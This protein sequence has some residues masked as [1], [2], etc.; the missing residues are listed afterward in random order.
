MGATGKT[1]TGFF[2]GGGGVVATSQPPQ[3]PNAPAPTVTIPPVN[4]NNPQVADQTPNDQNTPVT[5]NGLQRVSS[6]TDDELAALV[7]ASKKAIMPNFLADRADATQKFVF[8]AGLNDKPTVLDAND[9]NQYL[10]DNNINKNTIIARSV[11]GATYQNQQGYNV[12]YTAQQVQDMLM[13]SKLTYIGGKQGGQA[14]GA[15]AYF[16][17]VGD[18]GGTGYGSNTAVAVLN[19]KTAK[20]IDDYSLSRKAKSFA[21]SH[22]KFDKAVGGFNGRNQS[23][24]ALAMGY[25]VITDHSATNGKYIRTGSRGQ[26]TGDYYNI[27]DRSALVYR[28]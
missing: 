7:T 22:P 12:T 1:G 24:W 10:K 25:N 23:I 11:N 8:Q 20:I 3:T 9:F 5:P 19:P 2:G 18:N 21:Q 6:M 27:I 14:Y 28:K 26:A 16:A 4:Q 13:Y 15:G 17:M